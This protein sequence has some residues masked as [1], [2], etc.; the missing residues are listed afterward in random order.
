MKLL[1][2]LG[3]LFLLSSIDAKINPVKLTKRIH[4]N[5]ILKLGNQNSQE[6][7]TQIGGGNQNKQI[8][9][10]QMSEADMDDANNL[11]DENALDDEDIVND[12]DTLDDED[13]LDDE[14]VVEADLQ[15]M[16]GRRSGINKNIQD[17]T[18]QFGME[19]DNDQTDTTQ[20]GL[21][22]KNAQRKT[23]QIGGSMRRTIG[24]YPRRS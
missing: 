24:W 7:V 1:V 10:T 8:D 22:N 23:V 17:L 19:N 16:Q 20:L 11:D 14:D 5:W 13:A 15:I 9:I 3:C 21:S 2:I 6:G 12:E 18:N 4:R